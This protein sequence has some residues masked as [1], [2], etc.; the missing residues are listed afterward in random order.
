MAYAASIKNPYSAPN[1]W[2]RN[3]RLEIWRLV[4]K[5][6]SSQAYLEIFATTP[7][8]QKSLK[9]TVQDGCLYR[10]RSLAKSRELT[11]P[12][13]RTGFLDLEPAGG[14]AIVDLGLPLHRNQ[15][16]HFMRDKRG[17]FLTRC[18]ENK[19]SD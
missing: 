9:I 1:H 16:C 7:K 18:K 6:E 19:E 10:S 15:P 17:Y 3:S 11:W 5:A 14:G 12:T 4:R 2:W 13:C 8:V